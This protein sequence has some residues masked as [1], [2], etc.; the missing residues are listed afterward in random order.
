[1]TRDNS[2][3]KAPFLAFAHIGDLH[4]VDARQQNARD[5][6]SIVA[7]IELECAHQLD[8]VVLP[9]DNADNGLSSQYAIVATTLK[10]PS[11][12]VHA[13]PGD[14]DMETGSLDAFQAHLA[15][16]A[17]P[18]ALTIGGVRCLFLDVSGGGRGGPD[19]RLGQA[20]TNWLN[21][22]LRKA[23]DCGETAVLFMHTYPDDLKGEG[24]TQTLN[25]L[26]AQHDVALVD[27][28]H[29]HY[30]ELGNDGRTIF[31][32][33]RSTGQIEEGPV[34][35]TLITIDDGVVSWRFKLLEESFPLVMITAPT[36]HRLLRFDKQIVEGTFEVRAL[37]FGRNMVDRVEVQVEGGEW[38]PMRKD[39]GRLWRAN[40]SSP[41]TT[42]F[43]LTVRAFDETGRPGIH[44]IRPARQGHK[45]REH[46][47]LGSDAV[48]IGAWPENG[49]FGTQLGPNRN[50][51][52]IASK[53]GRS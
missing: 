13:I 12:P 11:L 26:T 2:R 5:L 6:L 18:K 8:F 41:D 29:T 9:G 19:F 37:V 33:T 14:H 34:G 42:E 20:Q 7:Q 52:P 49:I 35:Y 10:M 46:C 40:L 28:G 51:K 47:P 30:N 45:L 38:R 23:K 15:S 16:E 22:E 50:A 4:I 36:D 39:S 48:S 31:A 25:R 53:K 24:E 27:M 21:N 44:I 1:M 17:L 3:P 43:I 32:A